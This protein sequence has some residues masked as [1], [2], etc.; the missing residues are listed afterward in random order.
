MGIELVNLSNETKAYVNNLRKAIERQ[1]QATERL[2]RICRPRFVEFP[3]GSGQIRIRAD[4]VDC[5]SGE[6]DGVYLFIGGESGYRV[7]T[8]YADV[9]RMLNEALGVTDAP[10]GEAE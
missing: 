3:T 1:A 7:K 9:V 2:A 10:E 4:R 5:V 8:P 6:C